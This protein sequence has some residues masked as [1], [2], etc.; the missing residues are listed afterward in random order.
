MKFLHLGDLHLGKSL[1]DFDLIRD[2]KYILDQILGIIKEKSVD[3]VL[4]AGDVY[5]KA[6][7][8]EAAMN[9]L[10][11]FLSS[12][13]RSGVL[14]FM[15]S[16]N[17]DSDDR[18]NYGSDLFAANQIYI[19]SKYDGTLYRRTVTD[20]YGEA[21]IYLLPFVKASQVK[22]FFPDA[23]IATYDDAVRV[24]LAHA[25]VDPNRRNIIVAHQFVTGRSEDPSLG[26]SES[27]GTQSVG[28]VEKIGYDC[29]DVFDYAALGHIHSPQKVGREEVRYAGSP[30][31]YSLSEVNNAKSVPIITLG[32]KGD[33][34]LELLPLHP[35][36]DLRHIRGPMK[37]L[38][39]KTNITDPDDFIYVT[40]TDED[41]VNDAMGIFQQVY[42]NTVKIDYDNSHTRAIE[43]VDISRIAE[44]KSFSELIGVFYRLMYQCE[45]S[46]EEMKYMKVAAQEAGI[47]DE[48]DE[49]DH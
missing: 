28:L 40:L 38:L 29:F 4:I 41:V 31:K 9:L 19:A 48:T 2:Q 42:P 14:T 24:I 46:E 16:G 22:H 8:S 13:S 37:M 12:L 7:P 27:V 5:D 45:M 44:N 35:M 25:G 6:V 15:I 43:Q 34:S 30:L 20:A 39:D 17:H 36:R 47:I 21:D 32:A 18:L 49:T 3:G 1:G 10:D 26:G 11:Y 23:E 33:V